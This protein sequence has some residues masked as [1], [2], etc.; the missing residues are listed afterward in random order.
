MHSHSAC[1]GN[2]I[3]AC[4]IMSMHSNKRSGAAAT[5]HHWRPQYLSFPVIVS[6]VPVTTKVIHGRTPSRCI[7]ILHGWYHAIVNTVIKGLETV[8]FI[9]KMVSFHVTNS[10]A[11]KIPCEGWGVICNNLGIQFCTNLWILYVTG[12]WQCFMYDYLRLLEAY[13][14]SL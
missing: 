4:N 1:I 2:P 8:S 12:L 6:S 10:F 3:W 13:A 5:M 9:S 7:S 14:D 11:K